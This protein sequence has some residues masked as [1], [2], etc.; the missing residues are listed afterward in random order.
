MDD[1]VVG[2]C[3]MTCLFSQT[4]IAFG[5]KGINHLGS[6]VDCVVGGR[7]CRLV[8]IVVSSRVAEHVSSVRVVVSSR[9]VVYVAE[10]GGVT[11]N[12]SPMVSGGGLSSER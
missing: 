6:R 4:L 3:F 10:E 11:H 5:F 2:L 8:R 12:K 9:L 7:L 1:G